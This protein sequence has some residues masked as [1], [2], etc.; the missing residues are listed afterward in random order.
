MM[1]AVF[2]E[3]KSQFLA[4]LVYNVKLLRSHKCKTFLGLLDE[5]FRGKV[6]L[7]GPNNLHQERRG[8]VKTIVMEPYNSKLF[9]KS[10]PEVTGSISGSFTILNV[11]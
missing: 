11:N 8:Q 7:K 4:T 3:G 6:F 5:A 1:K 9:H 10:E 2:I